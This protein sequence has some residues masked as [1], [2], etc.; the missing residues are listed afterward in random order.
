[1]NGNYIHG[2]SH[3]NSMGNFEVVYLLKRAFPGL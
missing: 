3:R 1:M 2:K